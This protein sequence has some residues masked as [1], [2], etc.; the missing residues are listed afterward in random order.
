MLSG[1]TYLEI[2]KAN[3]TLTNDWAAVTGSLTYGGG[4]VVTNS[5][6]SLTLGDIFPLFSAS[7]FSGW[8]N[9]VTL[10]PLGPG[11][12][13]ATNQLAIDGTLRVAAPTP[14]LILPVSLQGTNLLLSIASEFG[15]TYVLQSASDLDSPT[16]WVGIST[17]N[18]TGTLLNI[19]A[20]VDVTQPQQ[21]FRLLAY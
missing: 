13:W 18:G 10:P 16:A 5:G 21:F 17:N 20:P 1:T 7:L 12:H 11:L 2:N 3:G 9:T 6:D 14:P 4:L 15:V 8:F 19:P